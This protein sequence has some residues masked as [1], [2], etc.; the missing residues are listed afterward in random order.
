MSQSRLALSMCCC[1][2]QTPPAGLGCPTGRAF[3][4]LVH[5]WWRL[6]RLPAGSKH[7]ITQ[8]AQQA[9]HTRK[10][11]CHHL[12]CA[13]PIT[14][15]DLPHSSSTWSSPCTPSHGYIRGHMHT[16]LYCG[17]QAPLTKDVDLV[18]NDV[19]GVIRPTCGQHAA[20]HWHQLLGAAAA[21]E[22]SGS[23]ERHGA[24]QLHS[25]TSTLPAVTTPPALSIHCM[26]HSSQLNRVAGVGTQQPGLRQGADSKIAP[27]Q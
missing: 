13:H 16:M 19:H 4:P 8:H 24:C 1:P 7:D 11:A 20:L 2:C 10:L 25:S 14:C 26:L 27:W 17:T 3:G 21:A 6:S 18:V 15:T 12:W 9:V 22:T 5:Q 23:S